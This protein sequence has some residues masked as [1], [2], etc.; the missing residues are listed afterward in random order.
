MHDDGVFIQIIQATPDDETTRLVYAD[1]LEERGDLRGEFLRVESRLFHWPRHEPRPAEVAARYEQLRSV[2]GGDWLAVVDRLAR[3][4]E[5][6]KAPQQ[7]SPAE[8]DGAGDENW[9]SLQNYDPAQEG[10]PDWRCYITTACTRAA[11]LPDDCHVLQTLRAFR[12]GHV[13]R[14]PGGASLIREYY[15]VAP[16]I[17]RSLVAAPDAPGLFHRLYERW[18]RKAVHLIEVGRNSSALRVYREMTGRL[19]RHT[20]QGGGAALLTAFDVLTGT[21]E[22]T[23]ASR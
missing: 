3:S 12:D 17:V 23:S 2:L 1:W 5:A 20:S 13:A 10:L 7:V 9:A 18:I 15:R 22:M 6:G 8:P 11:N 14:V 21:P 19:L 16:A 4:P